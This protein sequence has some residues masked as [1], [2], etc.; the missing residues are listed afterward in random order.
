MLTKST[1]SLGP[2]GT[3]LHTLAIVK[4]F[5]LVDLPVLLPTCLL[6]VRKV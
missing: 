2:I 5:R 1:K 4:V 3:T 6:K